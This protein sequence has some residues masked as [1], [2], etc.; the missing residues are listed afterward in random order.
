[1]IDRVSANPGRVLITPESGEP[2]YATLTRAD[3][4]TMEGTPLNKSSLLKDSTASLYGLN[5]DAVPDDMFQT[6]Y[7]R[8]FSS[9]STAQVW[10]K[11]AEATATKGSPAI[12]DLESGY[13]SNKIYLIKF[14]DIE[15]SLYPITC[16][17]YDSIGR[18]PT[19]LY[20][21]WIDS[22][23]TELQSSTGDSFEISE[24]SLLFFT[25]NNSAS[26]GIASML[27]VGDYLFRIWGLYW[28]S[29]ITS[30]KNLTFSVSR[31]S[32]AVTATIYEGAI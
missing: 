28:D 2:Y 11:V 6:L 21:K 8:L 24:N 7:N 23:L 25:M 13:K 14:T 3:N 31:T 12:F 9:Q 27:E 30:N 26:K 16:S 22:K 4:P 10:E 19:T 32:G 15:S 17:L 29:T 5:A 20:S 1:M 18:Y